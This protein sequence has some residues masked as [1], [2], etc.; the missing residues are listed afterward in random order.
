[1]EERGKNSIGNRGVNGGETVSQQERILKKSLRA[2]LPEPAQKLPLVRFARSIL[3]EELLDYYHNQTKGHLAFVHK[4]YKDEGLVAYV[5]LIILEI[6]A[7]ESLSQ[8]NHGLIGSHVDTY[9]YLLELKKEV[10]D[11]GMTKLIGLSQ[12][13]AEGLRQSHAASKKK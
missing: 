12:K 8:L 11:Q 7:A 4:R 2:L 3:G 6:A 1:M 5:K 13:K 10:T 9:N